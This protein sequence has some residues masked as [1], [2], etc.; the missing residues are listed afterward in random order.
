MSF[1]YAVLLR[2]LLVMGGALAAYG[3]TGIFSSAGIMPPNGLVTGGGLFVLFV[4]AVLWLKE[5]RLDSLWAAVLLP[6][7]A[8]SLYALGSWPTPECTPP[9]EPIT[10]THS[11][12]PVG[13]H[14]IA[15]VAPILT[16]VALVLL[17]RDVRSLAR[18]DR[19]SAETP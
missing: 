17:V 12:G 15:I 4:A 6:A 9:Y 2:V 11:C 10:P 8:Y 16:V 5:R 18:R 13:T 3:A 14:A 7:I 19:L 1:A